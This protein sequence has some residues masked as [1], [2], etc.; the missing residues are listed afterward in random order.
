MPGTNYSVYY[1]AKKDNSVTN[2][3]KMNRGASRNSF[4]N[5]E[6]DLIYVDTITTSQGANL[7]STTNISVTDGT[8]ESLDNSNGLLQEIDSTLTYTI[9]ANVDGELHSGYH[10]TLVADTA[11]EGTQRPVF[12]GPILRDG[13]SPDTFSTLILDIQQNIIAFE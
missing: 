10:G 4:N 3:W 12:R 2:R 1:F 7:P 11:D 9:A 5:I 8:W 6:A 13:I